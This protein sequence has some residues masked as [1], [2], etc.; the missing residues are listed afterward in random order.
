MSGAV[1]A[2]GRMVCELKEGSSGE[3]VL[4]LLSQ[5][6]PGVTRCGLGEE[7]SRQRSSMC[8]CIMAGGNMEPSVN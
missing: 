6:C 8:K 4:E 2:Y 5:G 1:R 3:M 7:H